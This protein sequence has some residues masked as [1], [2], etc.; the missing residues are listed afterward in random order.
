[1]L[2]RAL[3][4][5][6]GAA[7][8]ATAHPDEAAANFADHDRHTK[9]LLAERY[10]SRGWLDDEELE[11]IP[12]ADEVEQKRLQG[13]FG[14]YG[15]RLWTGHASLDALVRDIENQWD[16]G[17]SRDDLW[18]YLRVT[19]STTSC[20]TPRPGADQHAR[21]TPGGRFRCPAICHRAEQLVCPAGVPSLLLA[22]RPDGW[23]LPGRV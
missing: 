12:D 22:L 17:R 10:G 5:G 11:R 15:T 6:M 7:H 19:G 18:G 3:F 23:P 1:M 20:S 8:W 14:K 9:L 16:E 2:A 21:Y 13:K 4:E